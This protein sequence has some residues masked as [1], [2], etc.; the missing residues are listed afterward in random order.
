M[1]IHTLKE[2]E[3]AHLPLPRP[4]HCGRSC[5]TVTRRPH[6]TDLSYYKPLGMKGKE[7]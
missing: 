3:R 1:A 2:R 7:E 5:N 6:E 4:R